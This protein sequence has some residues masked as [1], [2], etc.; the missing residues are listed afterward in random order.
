MQSIN[1][2]L[3]VGSFNSRPYLPKFLKIDF[4]NITREV[5]HE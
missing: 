2:S 5:T 1:S 4:I 3:V